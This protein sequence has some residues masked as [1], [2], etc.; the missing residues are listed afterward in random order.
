MIPSTPILADPAPRDARLFLAFEDGLALPDGPITVLRPRAG[1][2]FAPLDPARLTL[3]QGF[4]PDHDALVQAGYRVEAD[5]VPAPVTLVCLPRSKAE[6][7]DLI[8]QAAGSALVL[9]DG[10]KTDGVDSILRQVR[11]RVDVL[12]VV[13]KGHG[14]LFWFDPRGADWTDWRALPEPVTGPAGTSFL[15][16]PGVFSS[17][18]IDPASQLLADTLPDELPSHIAD[19]GAGW[20][21]LSAAALTRQGPEVVHLIEAEANALA[22][23]RQNI[24][25]PRAQFHWADATS[26]ALPAPINGVIMNPPFHTGRSA[27]PALGLAF[28]ATA[29]RMLTTRGHLWMVGNRHLPYDA[30]LADTFA[31]VTIL[32]QTPSFKVWHARIPR[33]GKALVQG[34]TVTRQRR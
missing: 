29:A 17:D 8:A 3:V 1:D 4:R 20:G 16:L 15:T 24:T 19:L 26:F 23:A 25:D 13:S 34:R 6:A 7:L 30:A 10:Q 27:Q 31:E 5:F 32:A 22:L 14:K 2:N 11:A 28:I 18:G 12:G 33:R 21:V 9:V